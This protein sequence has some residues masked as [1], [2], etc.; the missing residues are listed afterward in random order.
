MIEK[1]I[2]EM[3][4]LTGKIDR[5]VRIMEVCGTHTMAAFRTGLRSML[6]GGVSLLS[7][8]GCPVCVTPDTYLD[9]AIALAGFPGIVVTTFGD[10]MRVP[11]SESSLERARALG[12]DVRIVYSPADALGAARAEP[13]RHFV[14]LGVGFETTTP[15]VAW[16]LKEAKRRGVR[17]FSVM[18]GH[19]TIPAAMNALLS[20]GEVHI[21]GFMCPGHVSVVIGSQAYE[22]LC[23]QQ[24]IPCVVTGFEAADMALGICMILRQIVSNRHEVEIEYSRTVTKQGNEAAQLACDEVFVRSDSEWRGLGVIPGTGLQIREDFA[25]HDTLR[26][27]PEKI[28][29]VLARQV[30]K[31]PSS[32]RCGDVL[33]GILSPPDCPLFGI[34]CTPVD[35]IGPCMV[36]SEGTC[37]AYFKYGCRQHY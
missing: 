2:T 22:P 23:R 30:R 20:G 19:K 27:H 5:P 4:T 28:D 10:M 12:S 1:Y 25:E 26:I 29:A 31:A 6:P 8:P 3:R 17:N 14:F 7:G 33:R 24:R 21:D 36:S 13:S 32:C 9:Q 15:T 37:S 34:R 18:C 11:G 35:P 16:A